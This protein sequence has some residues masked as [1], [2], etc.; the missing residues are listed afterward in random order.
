MASGNDIGPG[1]RI[2]ILGAD[3][4]IGSA[5]VRAALGAGA[6]VAA[7][8]AKSPWRLR[9][10]EDDSSL[11][12][13]NLAA[14][15]ERSRVESLE[16]V[17]AGAD[18]VALLAYQPPPDRFSARRHEHEVNA[19]GTAAIGEIAARAGVRLVF[20]SSA[21]VY[22]P[23]HDQPVTEK[24]VP[25]PQTPYAEAKLRAERLLS[26]GEGSTIRRQPAVCDGLR[27]R[28]GRSAG[29]SLLHQG[30]PAL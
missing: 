5:V 22:G 30:L 7:F 19:A 23:W 20:A 25:Q 4:F 15:W 11:E 16:P 10:V 14:W 6:T 3:G 17:L 18:A 27:T 12:I 28:R 24:T 9:D 26:S 29:D 1:R 8:C 13:A 2:A 21:D